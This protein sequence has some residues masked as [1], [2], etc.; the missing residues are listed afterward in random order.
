M[1]N[2]ANATEYRLEIGGL[3]PGRTYDVAVAALAIGPDGTL[4]TPVAAENVTVAFH[5]LHRLGVYGVTLVGE[6]ACRV[7]A[8]IH[9]IVPTDTLH[10]GSAMKCMKY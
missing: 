3:T 8:D 7:I 4:Q 2:S 9:K 6:Y 5:L 10:A 1:A